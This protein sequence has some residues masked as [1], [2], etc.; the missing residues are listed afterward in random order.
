MQRYP[1]LLPADLDKGKRTKKKINRRWKEKQC[2]IS[3][4][5][6]Y[7]PASCLLSLPLIFPEQI[8]SFAVCSN[9]RAVGKEKV[10]ALPFAML[11]PMP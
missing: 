3:L 9:T 5:L 11:K 4:I 10:R 6:F 1:S 7:L 2:V 8:L